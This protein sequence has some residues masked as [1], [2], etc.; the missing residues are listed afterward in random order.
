M[1]EFQNGVNTSKTT[2]TLSHCTAT[3][4]DGMLLMCGQVYNAAIVGLFGTDD[5]KIPS[6]IKMK[7]GKQQR[8]IRVPHD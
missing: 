2:G 5:G 1:K 3:D 6:F 8:T 7:C 4:N